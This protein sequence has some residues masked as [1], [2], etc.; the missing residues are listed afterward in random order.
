MTPELAPGRPGEF[1]RG[2]ALVGYRGTG[3]STVG[4]ILADRLRRPFLDADTELEARAGRSVR[5]IFSEDGEPAF[6][7]QEERLLAELIIEFPTAVIATGGGIVMRASNR[8]RL[9]EFG[10]VVWLKAAPQELAHRLASEPGGLAARPALSAAGTLE[11][12]ARVLAARTPWYREVAAAEIDTA[13]KTPDQVAC[14]VLET[15][16]T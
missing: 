9:R 1:D 4:R 16:P 15:W 7:D 13:G 2:L 14:A 8:S 10:H 12:I 5:A 3:K 6:R 11:E